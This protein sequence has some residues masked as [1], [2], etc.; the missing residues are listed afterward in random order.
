LCLALAA[1]CAASDLARQVE[2]ALQSSP[3]AA[4]AFWGIRVVDAET[5]SVVFSLSDRKFFVPAS[6]ARIFTT[7][8]ALTRLGPDYRFVTRVE[9]SC[10]PDAKGLVRELRLIGGGDPT[11]SGRVLP[12]DGR[13][14]T[15]LNPLAAIEALADAVA[16]KGV[17]TVDGDIVGDDSAWEWDP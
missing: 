4:G 3:E 16:A 11:L 10:A 15:N 5:G 2:S 8:L 6:K 12:Y 7:S 13:D 1:W 14:K 17:R 9:S